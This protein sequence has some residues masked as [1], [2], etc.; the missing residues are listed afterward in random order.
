MLFHAPVGLAIQSW[1]PPQTPLCLWSVRWI[2]SLP[3]CFSVSCRSQFLPSEVLRLTCS[4]EDE[5]H[6]NANVWIYKQH[7]QSLIIA[8]SN[9]IAY[10]MS[11]RKQLN[12]RVECMWVYVCLIRASLCPQQSGLSFP[13]LN[14]NV[15]L[16]Y[17]LSKQFTFT[18]RLRRPWNQLKSS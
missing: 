6:L 9:Q 12:Y 2:T 14:Y 16:Y 3:Q 15:Y 13:T 11:V 18:S 7:V 17:I 4:S 1:P 5:A 8:A 10:E